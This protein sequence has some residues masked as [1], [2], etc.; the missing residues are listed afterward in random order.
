MQVVASPDARRRSC[1]SERSFKG[2]PD[3]TFSKNHLICYCT[4][5][6]D[7]NG[8]PSISASST[9]NP[10][11]DSAPTTKEHSREGERCGCWCCNRSRYWGERCQGRDRR[12][13]SFPSRGEENRTAQVTLKERACT[14]IT[15]S[16]RSNCV[17]QLHGDNLDTD[18]RFSCSFLRSGSRIITAAA[19]NA[20]AACEC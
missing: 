3:E 9:A 1:G 12:S 11:T 2:G 7:C 10:T 5:C 8:A 18:R 20:S 16:A 6:N 14:L 4:R 13:W 15:G 17:Y 19:R